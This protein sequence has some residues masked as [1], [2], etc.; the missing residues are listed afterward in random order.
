MSGVHKLIMGGA[1]VAELEL[2][3]E[4]GGSLPVVMRVR[5][6]WPRGSGELSE[7]LDALQAWMQ[8]ILWPF[9]ERGVKIEQTFE[10]IQ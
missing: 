1:V 5:N 3:E 2:G 10:R 4:S 8:P 6:H 7:Q 9:Q